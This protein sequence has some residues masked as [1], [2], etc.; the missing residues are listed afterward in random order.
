[1]RF[2]LL[3]VQKP[4]WLLMRWQLTE[5]VH[6]KHVAECIDRQRLWSSVNV[7]IAEA[8]AETSVL[9]GGEWSLNTVVDGSY[10]RIRTSL[11]IN[12]T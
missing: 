8:I 1:M 3:I 5:L 11:C 7:V 10:A 4:E 9:N 12:D 2:D 6:Q